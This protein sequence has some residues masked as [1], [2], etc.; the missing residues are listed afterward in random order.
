MM[1]TNFSNYTFTADGKKGETFKTDNVCFSKRFSE[2][3]QKK[4]L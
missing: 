3:T 2:K 1:S 4:I